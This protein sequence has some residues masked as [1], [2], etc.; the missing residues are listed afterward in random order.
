MTRNHSYPRSPKIQSIPGAVPSSEPTTEYSCHPN[1]S[2][3]RWRFEPSVGRTPP[4]PRRLQRPV[5]RSE[6]SPTNTGTAGEFAWGLGDWTYYMLVRTY[7]PKSW[8]SAVLETQAWQDVDS[9][10]CRP[11]LWLVLAV[12]AFFLLMGAIAFFTVIHLVPP[13]FPVWIARLC[14]IVFASLGGVCFA[15]AVGGIISPAHIRHA[16]ASVLPS[17]P[18]EPV[19]REGS[20]VHGRLTHELTEDASGWQLRPSDTSLA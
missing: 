12:G 8:G 5:P 18:Q 9:E 4:R 16:A 7:D 19:T 13:G 14:T 2:V 15:W 6:L 1:P 20:V 10:V 17:V 3:H 11:G